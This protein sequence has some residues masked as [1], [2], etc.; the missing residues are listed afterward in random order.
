VEEGSLLWRDTN[1]NIDIIRRYIDNTK[2]ENYVMESVVEHNDRTMLLVAEPGMGK[3]IFL[4]YMAHEIKKWKPSVWVLRINLNEHTKELEDIKFEQENIEK[5]REFL[6]SAAH[7]SKESALKATK[8]IF[9]QSLEQTG[10]MVIILDG[11]N[12]LSP[13]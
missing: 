5:C 7:S 4:S 6:W 9:L 3:S 12:E 11:F 1:C 13:D 2:C 10:K 8:E